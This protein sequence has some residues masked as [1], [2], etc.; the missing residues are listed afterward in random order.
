MLFKKNLEYKKVLHPLKSQ[1]TKQ[2]RHI[3]KKM[4]LTEQF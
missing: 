1:Y 3:I 4:N 2:E